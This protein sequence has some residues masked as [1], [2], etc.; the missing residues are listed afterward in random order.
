[1]GRD[2]KAPRHRLREKAAGEPGREHSSLKAGA[3]GAPHLA[4][5][6][7]GLPA[8]PAGRPSFWRRLWRRRVSCLGSH[9]AKGTGRSCSEN[10]AV[11]DQAAAHGG[12]GARAML[13]PFA[14]WWGGEPSGSNTA[15][16][17]RVFL[18]HSRPSPRSV[19]APSGGD[20]SPSLWCLL[21]GPQEGAHE[22]SQDRT[23]RKATAGGPGGGGTVPRNISWPASRTF[24]K[25]APFLT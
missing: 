1:M 14:R 8:A 24:H 25:P 12:G 10:N 23:E 13:P 3:P 2:L 15:S 9:K 7:A 11:G 20:P 5:R 22:R 19:H 16:T 17:Q 6:P 21:L 18:L 4:P